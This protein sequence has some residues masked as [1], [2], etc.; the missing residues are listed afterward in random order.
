ML[1]LKMKNLNVVLG[2]MLVG[3][4]YHTPLFLHNVATNLIGRAILVVILVYLALVCDFSCAVIFSLI[5]IVLFQNTMEGFQEG[6]DEGEEEEEEDESMDEATK[7]S[8]KSGGN[9]LKDGATDA[10]GV[11]VDRNIESLGDFVKA[12]VKNANGM[13]DNAVKVTSG[14]ENQEGFLGMNMLKK[15]KFLK[16]MSN[17]IFGNMTDLDRSIKT[18]SEKATRDASKD[19]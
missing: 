15:N 16:K 4:M 9:E 10:V 3:L 19:L 13:A 14:F 17:N 7:N 12:T 5:I 2:I 18:S 11:S 6:M 1:K 8:L